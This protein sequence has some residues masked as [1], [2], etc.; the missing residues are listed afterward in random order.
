MSRVAFFVDAGYLFA[1]GSTALTGETRPRTEL[2]LNEAAVLAE[3]LS[4]AKAK[5]DGVRMLRTYWYDASPTSNLTTQH[6]SLANADYVKL[7]LGAM[8]GQGLC[9]RSSVSEITLAARADRIGSVSIDGAAERG[10]STP[11]TSQGAGPQ[12]RRQH[13]RRAD[14]PAQRPD[15]GQQQQAAANDCQHQ[16]RDPFVLQAH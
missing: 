8:N 15:R 6:I 12:D 11:R 9:A 5:C 3:L 14:Q 13:E 16:G 7:R 4:V 1:Q 2:R 10:R